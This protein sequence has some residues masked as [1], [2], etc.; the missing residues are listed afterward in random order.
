MPRTGLDRPVARSRLGRVAT[1][2]VWYESGV[3]RL[4]NKVTYKSTNLLT[5]MATIDTIL[6]SRVLIDIRVPLKRGQFYERWIYV[7]PKCVEWMR[8]DV[9]KMVTG[10]LQAPQTPKEQ[11]HNRIQEWIAGERMDYG[12]MFSR[13]TPHSD[14]VLE[15]KTPDLRIFGWM[16]QPKKFVAVFGDYADDYK[17]PTKTKDYGDARRTVVKARDSL[18][19]DGIKYVT[20]AF[21]DLI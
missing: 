13:L 1:A 18:P 10:R 20:G 12:P 5:Q 16:Y 11:L 15:L 9:P 2:L 17:H 19:L 3:V 7:Y 8:N 21:N 4:Y 14:F 6:A